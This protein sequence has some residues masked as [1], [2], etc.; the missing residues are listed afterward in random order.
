MS[1]YLLFFFAPMKIHEMF[2]SLSS[3][4]SSLWQDGGLF[5]F[6]EGSRGQLG[7]GST[8]N[9]LL[10]RRVLELMGTEVS[11]ITCGRY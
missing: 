2:L 8:N 10:P 11:Q 3:A 6:G 1:F 5:T 7:H 9:E 4:V